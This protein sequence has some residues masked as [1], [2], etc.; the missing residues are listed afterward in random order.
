MENKG[1][2]PRKQPLDTEILFVIWH[3]IWQ[4]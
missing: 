3:S 1:M 4:S 2:K